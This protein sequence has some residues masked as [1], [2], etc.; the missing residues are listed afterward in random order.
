MADLS[1]LSGTSG[2]AFDPA[3][4]LVEFEAVG[5]GFI[6]RPEGVQ[7]CFLLHGL[8]PETNQQAKRLFDIIDADLAKRAAV[9]AFVQAQNLRTEG[10]A[11]GRP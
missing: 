8:P 11:H 10:G 7:I 3:A 4:W 1:R 5:G 9:K 6:V 2:D